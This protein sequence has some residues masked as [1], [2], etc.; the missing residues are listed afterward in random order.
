MASAP[1]SA[2][3]PVIS[4]CVY[5]PGALTM[6]SRS[7]GCAGLPSSSRRTSVVT[8]KAYSKNG[9][10]PYPRTAAIS[11]PSEPHI[12]V[13]PASCSESPAV[14]DVD[15]ADDSAGCD[16]ERSHIEQAAPIAHEVHGDHAGQRPHEHAHHRRTTREAEE[17]TGQR[18]HDRDDDP[19][20]S[21][22]QQRGK[23]GGKRDGQQVEGD[24]RPQP[25]RASGEP[26]HPNEED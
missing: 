3:F 16:E 23:H 5:V 11:P 1:A 26:D 14:R 24:L 15:E 22:Q 10:R 4:E 18:R 12:A 17:D 7:S 6:S 20:A 8:P 2:R 19:L 21:S 25:G 9:S 13:M